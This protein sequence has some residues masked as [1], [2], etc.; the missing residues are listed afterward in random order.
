MTDGLSSL[1][2]FYIKSYYIINFAIEHGTY[3]VKSIQS[4]TPIFS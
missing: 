3:I 4:N 1:L 2:F